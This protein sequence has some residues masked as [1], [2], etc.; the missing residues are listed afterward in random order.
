MNQRKIGIGCHPSVS[1]DVINIG[2][3]AIDTAD[4]DDDQQKNDR[5]YKTNDAEFDDDT[6]HSLLL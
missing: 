1:L 6:K 4:I 2:E 3:F 5:Q